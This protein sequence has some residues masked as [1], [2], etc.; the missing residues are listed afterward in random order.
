MTTPTEYL[1][2]E[3]GTIP[4]LYILKCRRINYLYYLLTCNQEE[5]LAKVFRAQ[6][7][8][9]SKGDWIELVQKDLE[10]FKINL[11][12]DEIKKM[13]QIIFK[14]KVIQACKTYTLFNYY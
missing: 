2:L 1:Y 10:D 12:F 6:M 11:S 13:N 9:P 4:I 7:R 3:T 14:K 5:M 8:R